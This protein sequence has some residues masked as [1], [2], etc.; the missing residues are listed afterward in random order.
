MPLNAPLH[1]IWPAPVALE[2]AADVA[3]DGEDGGEAEAAAQLASTLQ[4]CLKCLHV[5]ANALLDSFTGGSLTALSNV[6]SF[7]VELFKHFIILD[8]SVVGAHED[9]EKADDYQS[10]P[11]KVSSKIVKVDPSIPEDLTLLERRW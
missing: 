11:S 8:V 9:G 10:D 3:E 4:S 2:A 7:T 6:I 5:D 1:A